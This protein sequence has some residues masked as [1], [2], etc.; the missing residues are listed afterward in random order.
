VPAAG[1]WQ[2]TGSVDLS[3]F[4]RLV[5]NVE[6]VYIIEGFSGVADTAVTTDYVNGFLASDVGSSVVCPGVWGADFGL[7]IL[8]LETRLLVGWLSPGIG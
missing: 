4:E 2:V 7:G 6:L 3:P 1:L 5:S 8:G